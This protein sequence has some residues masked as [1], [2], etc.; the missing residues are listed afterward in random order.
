MTT[1][2]PSPRL[3]G[4]VAIITGGGTGI[5]RATAEAFVSEGADVLVVGR[6][7][8]PLKDLANAHDGRVKYF[9]ADLSKREN[10]KA[11]I[12]YALEIFGRLDVLVNNAGA[13]TAKPLS[14]MTDDEIDQMF[15][16]NVTGLLALSRE[17]IPALENSKGSI[18]NISSVAAQSAVPGMSAYGATKAGVDRLSKILAVELGPLGIRVNVVSPG[19]IQTDMLSVMPEEAITQM[20]NE[21]SALRR[22]GVPDDVAQSITWLV[23]DSAGF[24]TGQ[25]VQASGGLLIS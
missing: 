20:V 2:I 9:Q 18:V 19:L 1:Q 7:E 24:V 11:V 12:D 22:L 16:I 4:K 10:A 21:A 6:R 8:Q 25:V 14:V 5:G 17:A 3:V 23:S 15:A 13:V